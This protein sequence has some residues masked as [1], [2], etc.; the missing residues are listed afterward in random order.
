M[1][2]RH[3]DAEEAAESLKR[4]TL[5]R[6]ERFEATGEHVT[7]EAVMAWLGSWGTDE[8]GQPPKTLR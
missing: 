8:E 2:D 6:W 3:L 7:N 5:E 1:R 4:E